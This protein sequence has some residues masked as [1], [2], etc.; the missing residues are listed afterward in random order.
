MSN[1]LVFV[2][3]SK[4]HIC[5]MIDLMQKNKFNMVN[6]VRLCQF[7]SNDQKK[8]KA[9]KCTMNSL[10]DFQIN[11]DDPMPFKNYH[12]LIEVNDESWLN[13]VMFQSVLRYS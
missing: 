13:Q 1:G 4:T 6:N 9:I 3:T 2:W 8:K 12:Q 11:G 10:N 7:K 5:N